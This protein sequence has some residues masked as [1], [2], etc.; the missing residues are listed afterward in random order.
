MKKNSEPMANSQP[1][2]PLRR[3]MLTIGASLVIATGAYFLQQ[4]FAYATLHRIPAGLRAF[5]V[6]APIPTC[7]KWKDTMPKTRAEAP[8]RLY[9][10]ARKLWRSKIEW[11]LTRQEALGILHDVQA[12]A[13]QGDWGARAL[14]AYFYRVGLGPLDK[15]HVLDPDL[16]KSVEIVRMAVAAG[17][18]WG[19]FDLGVA[20]EHGYGDAVQDRQIAWALYLKAAKLG[21]PDA[22]MALA[23]AYLKAQR[24]DAENAMLMCAYTQGHGPAAYDLG[25]REDI[26]KNFA[27]A[28][29]YYQVGTKFGS[30][31]SAAALM[32]IFDAEDWSSRAKQDQIA[33]KELG[34]VPD[35]ERTRRYKQID[36]ALDLNRDLKFARVDHALPLPPA[37]LPAWKGIDDAIA[38]ERDGPPSY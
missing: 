1:R 25:M 10:N 38:P 19:Y 21:S 27:A 17:Q 16:D 32:F 15:N 31:P 12:A 13:N 8:Y 5:D 24:H 20:H 7:S 30:E 22:Q 6:N 35:E 29:A 9:M 37:E 2:R 4:R 3:W 26:L 18:A 11:Q 36:Q 28:M 23:S 14:M 34:A 33:L